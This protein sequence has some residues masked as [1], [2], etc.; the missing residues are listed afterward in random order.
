MT[1]SALGGR[2]EGWGG[3]GWRSHSLSDFVAAQKPLVCLQDA[4]K[5]TLYSLLTSDMLDFASNSVVK[6]SSTNSRTSVADT[7]QW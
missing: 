4:L 3:G 7:R 1:F 5:Q 6:T 2:G